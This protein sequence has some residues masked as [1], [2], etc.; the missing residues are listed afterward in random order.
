MAQ[1]AQLI[2]CCLFI[3]CCTVTQAEVLVDCCLSVHTGNAIPKVAVADYHKQISGQ[4]CSV[5]ATILETRNG[6]KLCAPSDQVWVQEV[7]KHVDHLKKFCK[8]TNY[9]G[10]RCYGVK[11]V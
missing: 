10:K 1:W 6:H 9:K 2:F 7:E 11:R 8:K 4:G 3:S 5:D